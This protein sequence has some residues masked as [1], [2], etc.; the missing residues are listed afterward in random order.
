MIEHTQKLIKE[1]EVVSNDN[2]MLRASLTELEKDYNNLR[3]G[4]N[5]LLDLHL[6]AR[7]RM[8]FGDLNSEFQ[9]DMVVKAGLDK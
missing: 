6:E 7:E 3:R 1:I 2:L 5:E 4:F 8:G 9:Y